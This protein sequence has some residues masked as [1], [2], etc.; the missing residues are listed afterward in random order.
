MSLYRDARALETGRGRIPNQ[1][2]HRDAE[3]GEISNAL[4]VIES[5]GDPRPIR[6][7]GPSGVGKTTIARF[8]VQ[9]LQKQHPTVRE[10]FVDVMDSQT[11]TAVLYRILS[12]L[13]RSR[14]VSHRAPP[15]RLMEELTRVTDTDETWIIILDEVSRLNPDAHHLLRKLPT[16]PS[17]GVILVDQGL[18]ALFA[19]LDPST[20]NRYHQTPEITLDL[21]TN[22]ELTD[23]LSARAQAAFADTDRIDE[24]AFGLIAELAE[25]DARTAINSL[26]S[27]AEHVRD[28]GERI[29]VAT[30]RNTAEKA[31]KV[32]AENAYR[33]VDTAHRTVVRIVL[34]EPGLTGPDLYE[35][36]QAELGSSMSRRT[37]QRWVAYLIEKD[38]IEKHGE[39]KG[40]TYHPT[41]IAVALSNTVIPVI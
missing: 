20:T 38:L 24:E 11:T 7:T 4:G 3:L 13:D 40:A 2:P 5:G 36:S 8:A 32:T 33:S 14:G 39:T 26:Y 10:A 17:I 15:S 22:T 23:I 30:V 25:G 19:E 31:R 18:D 16:L 27:A 9:R 29:T 35:R 37:H 34:D 21:Y 12:D 41:D 28:T 6:I 1:L